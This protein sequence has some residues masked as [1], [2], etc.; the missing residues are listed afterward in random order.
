MRTF[1]DSGEPARFVTAGQEGDRLDYLVRHGDDVWLYSVSLGEV[2]LGRIR[3]E[4]SDARGLVEFVKEHDLRRGVPLVYILLAACFWVLSLAM[5]IYLAH[6]IS[7]PIQ[8]LTAGLSELAAGDLKARVPA[9]RDDEIGRAMQAF[10]DM[11]CKLQESTER[12]VYLGQLASWQML[13]RKMAHEVKN[14]LTPIR[15]TVEEMLAR[16]DRRRPRRS[17]SRPR[18]S[19]WTRSRR[20]SAAFAPSRSS[21]PSRRWRPRRWM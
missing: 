8:Q 7:R 21:P 4:I 10:N 17:W 19:W 5:L 14:S 12:L 9:G 2:A 1:A 3:G 16:Y 20:W 11:A 18:R 13:A 6:R 15:L